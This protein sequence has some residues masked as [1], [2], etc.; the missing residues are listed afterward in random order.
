MTAAPVLD[1]HTTAAIREAIAAARSG[2]ISDALKIGERALAGGGDPAALSA[3]L[4]TLHCRTGNLDVG[5]AHLRTAHDLRPDDLT[6]ATNLAAALAETGDHDA[7]LEVATAER[8]KADPTFGL[9]RFRAFAAQATERFAEAIEAYEHIVGNVPDDWEAWNNLGNARSGAGDASGAVEALR[10]AFDL[11]PRS[12]PIHLNFALTLGRAGNFEEA[13]Q[14]LREMAARFPRDPNP[15]R[16]LHALLKDLG[17][18]EE[19]NDAIEA[20]VERAPTDVDLWLA[21]A[22]QR[23]MLLRT[24][25]AEEAYREALRLDPAKPLANLGL[26]VVFELTNRTAELASLVHEA[27]QR[28]VA[29]DALNFIR[30]F[31]H[32]RGKRFAEGLA[33]LEQVP[34][35]LE[36]ARRYHLLGQLQEGV[37]KYDEAFEAYIRMNEIQQAHPTRPLERAEAYRQSI[38]GHG[39]T[40]TDAWARS[41]RPETDID[42]R[43][44]PVFLVGFPRS[45]T[46]LLDTMLMGHPDIE[47]LEEEPALGRAI[48]L[49]PSLAEM[50]GASD[51]QV[52]AARD[53]YFRAAAE[54]TPLAA[55]K[56][57]IDKNPLTMNAVPVI[58]RLFPEARIILAIRHPCDVVLSCFVTNFKVNDGMA[59]FL[60]LDTAAE[61]YDLSFT[62]FERAVQ[63]LEPRVH[64][65]V[66]ENVVADA[67][68]ELRSLIEFLGL[69][70]S[71]EVLQ[72]ESTALARGR[73]KTASYA[74]V[75]EPIYTRSAGRWQNYRKH[76]AP[77]LPILEPWVRKFGYSL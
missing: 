6:I 18:D 73:I 58:R 28:G 23:L 51:E 53:E 12:P 20:A 9:A 54:L 35:Q 32:R 57:V 63:L 21:L 2:R 61:L 72:H 43:P 25:A 29:E 1:D 55:G 77:V 27:Q 16:E 22:S 41:W 39:E 34:E 74:Q 40:M 70:W 52:R 75:F 66:Y 67:E 30:A 42:N 64:R 76:L 65:V 5:I 48:R 11:N 36:T 37:G 17:R 71:D 59:N 14:Q 7:T 38:R 33:A 56:V 69:D 13:E 4:G 15:L 45:G 44:A 50:P 24:A 62:S 3:M 46:T 31:D 68:S 47:I 10:R 8:A 19:A 60:Q 26:A 49:L